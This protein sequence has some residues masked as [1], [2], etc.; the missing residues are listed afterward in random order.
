M[1]MAA[2]AVDV[3]IVEQDSLH[4]MASGKSR[5]KRSGGPEAAE[6]KRQRLEERR[7]QKAEALARKRKAEARARVV[8]TIGLVALI[9][10]AF[11]F[12]FLRTSTPSEI[13]GHEISSFGG[14]GV[15]AH[16]DQPVI[17][18]MTPP[19]QG[20]HAG[21]PAA[22]GVH[23]APVPNENF[24]HSL[25]HGAVGL[26]FD[27]TRA[28]PQDIKELE[29]IAAAADTNVLSAP[30][31]GME[32]V[33]S[34]VSWG[35]RMDLQELDLAAVNEY[36]DVFAGAGPEPGQDCPNSSS[37][38]FVPETDPTEAEPTDDGG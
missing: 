16:T 33:F 21:T 10:V 13:G 3:V 4:A 34:I 20:E 35:E 24:V 6:R 37:S 29:A 5:K 25:E 2:S 23:S 36:V 38:P 30:F 14:T 17:Y 12:F 9:G 8:R 22:C 32:P 18:E 28:A 7:Q 1:R 26:L 27:P 31:E 15:G 11:W 19:V